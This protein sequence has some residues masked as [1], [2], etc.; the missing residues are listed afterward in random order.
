VLWRVF[1]KLSVWFSSGIVQY[2]DGLDDQGIVV[3]FLA[4]ASHFSLHWIIQ[5]D[6]GAHPTSYSL[7]IGASFAGCKVVGVWKVN[8]PSSAEVKNEY[9][10]SYFHIPLS[11]CSIHWENFTLGLIYHE[12]ISFMLNYQ[13]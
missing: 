10:Y 13:W 5:T 7:G 4:G 1:T 11:L 8:T 6:A 12:Q 3:Q 2:R 9:S